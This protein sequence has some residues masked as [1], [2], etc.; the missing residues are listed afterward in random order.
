MGGDERDVLDDPPGALESVEDPQPPR[1]LD[2]LPAPGERQMSPEASA[3]RRGP[4]VVRGGADRPG[5]RGQVTGLVGDVREKDARGIRTG[6]GTTSTQPYGERPP[7]SR[8]L[9]EPVDQRVETAVG[10]AGRKA[11]V[12]WNWSGSLHR[13]PAPASRREARK[14]SSSSVTWGG[15]T[16]ATNIRTTGQYA[17]P[18]LP[19]APAFPGGPCPSGGGSLPDSAD[20]YGAEA[21]PEGAGLLT[22]V[23]DVAG[24]EVAP[25][26]P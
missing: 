10:T 5:E 6:E 24:D 12:T 8:R 15:G 20:G 26:A 23:E 13:S 9:P 14:S 22:G 16:T 11:S 3:V 18:P 19:T 7:P 25:G 2:R 21:I 17:A 1:R 4:G